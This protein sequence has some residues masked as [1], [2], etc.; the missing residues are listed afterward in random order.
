MIDSDDLAF[1][2]AKLIICLCHHHY[3]SLVRKTK[4][5]IHGLP[6]VHIYHCRKTEI[7]AIG[8]LSLQVPLLCKVDD[9]WFSEAALKCVLPGSTTLLFC[10][11][12]NEMI[13]HGTWL[14]K[15]PGPNRRKNVSVFDIRLSSRIWWPSSSPD[16]QNKECR[17]CRWLKGQWTVYL[18]SI[19]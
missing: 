5:Q 9:S 12:K 14:S 18:F 6:D 16:L 17:S 1:K 3:T 13:C 15:A 11:S 2:S 8:C 4:D 19:S 10:F 7:L